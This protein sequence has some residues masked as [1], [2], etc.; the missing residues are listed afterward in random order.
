MKGATR[1]SFSGE[2]NRRLVS[3]HAPVKGA[4]VELQHAVIARRITTFARTAFFGRGRKEQNM[5][6]FVKTS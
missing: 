1:C 5:L 6:F 2:I 4:T 3:I